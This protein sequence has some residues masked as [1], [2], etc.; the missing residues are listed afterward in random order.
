MAAGAAVVGGVAKAYVKPAMACTVHHEENRVVASIS[1]TSEL[2]LETGERVKLLGV[3][4][5]AALEADARTALEAIVGR[6]V[7]IAAAGRRKDRYGRWLAQVFA[8]DQVRPKQSPT[9][10]TD[11]TAEPASKR[12]VQGELVA[13]GLARAAAIPGNAT[14]LDELIKAEAA[15]RAQGQGHWAN[16]GFRDRDASAVFDLAALADTFQTVTGEILTVSEERDGGSVILKFA[17]AL[18]ALARADEVTGRPHQPQR[19]RAF[20]VVI[21]AHVSFDLGQP[22]EATSTTKNLRSR[23]RDA[24]RETRNWQPLVGAEVRVR[25]WI[26]LRNGE[27]QMTINHGFELERLK[28]QSGTPTTRTPLQTEPTR[29]PIEAAR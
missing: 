19:N 24:S 27:P 18:D 25:G 23:S 15:A 28:P 20:K 22:A 16:G 4:V 1:S 10:P 12:W 3:H 11:A 5:P 14:C 7:D 26:E 29:I 13:S 9:T 8:V 21:P 17:S 6:P 2:A